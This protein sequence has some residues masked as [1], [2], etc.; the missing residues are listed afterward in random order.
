M[1]DEPTPHPESR[2]LT[3][4]KRVVAREVTEIEAANI[5]SASLVPPDVIPY[6]G[7]ERFPPEDPVVVDP[8]ALGG[9]RR[10]TSHQRVYRWTQACSMIAFLAAGISVICTMADDVHVA[11]SLAAPALV[12]GLAATYL[13]GRNSL[14]RRWRGWAIAS[15]VF[16]AVA[17]T[18]TWLGP[19]IMGEDRPNFPTKPPAK[20]VSPSPGP[21][22]RQP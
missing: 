18:L 20:T 15:A 8:T 17:L 5:E 10:R 7:T 9:R 21:D 3:P 12:I 4:R 16:A 1:S 19:A 13:S 14:A 11:L 22:V 2:A 6:R